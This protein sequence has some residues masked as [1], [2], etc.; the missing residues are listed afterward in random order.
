MK[1]KK[2][3]KIYYR[4]IHGGTHCFENIFPESVVTVISEHAAFIDRG[5]CEMYVNR[6]G[7]N[8]YWLHR[9]GGPALVKKCGEVAFFE[10][11]HTVKIEQL[12]NIDDD[13]LVIL[14]LKYSPMKTNHFYH[15]Y[16]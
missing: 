2:I 9:T 6:L 10:R 4:G 16:N 7:G 1:H 15:R 11:G 12:N 5:D 13:N 14:T 3:K 8:K